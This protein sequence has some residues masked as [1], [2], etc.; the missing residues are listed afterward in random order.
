MIAKRLIRDA[1]RVGSLIDDDM[2]R[3]RHARQQRQIIVVDA[4]DGVVGD[5]VLHR[6]RR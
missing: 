2:R 3:G 5:D 4:D 6:L 1:Q